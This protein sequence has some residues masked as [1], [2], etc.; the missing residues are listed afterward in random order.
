MLYDDEPLLIPMPGIEPAKG[1]LLSAEESRKRANKKADEALTKELQEIA[2]KINDASK[3][4][5]YSYGNDGCLN[6]EIIARLKALGYKVE[7]G[8]QYNQSWYSIS[9]K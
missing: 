8:N 7:V 6:P 2:I 1:Q 3:R 5:N 4:G 9:W